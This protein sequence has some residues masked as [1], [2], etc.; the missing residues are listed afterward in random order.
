MDERELI[1]ERLRAYIHPNAVE[2]VE[3]EDA[4]DSAVDAQ[5]AYEQGGAGL[6]P[7]VASFSIGD[8]SATMDAAGSEICSAARAILF[9]AGLLRRTLPTA[10]RL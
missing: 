1:E 6:G 4:F 9:N 10:K 5:L 7:G 3:Q 2:T 8:F